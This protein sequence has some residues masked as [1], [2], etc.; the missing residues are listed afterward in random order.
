MA[1]LTIYGT[2]VITR[3]GYVRL[4]SGPHR[5]KYLHRVVWEMI[6]GHPLPEGFDVHHMGGK[7]ENVGE[8]LLAL[9]HNLHRAE[10]ERCPY[11]G[12]FLSRREVAMLY[13]KSIAC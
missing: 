4:K 10:R 6:A 12:R 3:K 5:D 9:D 8:K 7:R 13:G 2:A 11:T 1:Y